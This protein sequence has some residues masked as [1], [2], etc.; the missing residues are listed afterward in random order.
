MSDAAVTCGHVVGRLAVI[1]GVELVRSGVVFIDFLIVFHEIIE[2][3]LDVLIGHL[4]IFG[5]MIGHTLIDCVIDSLIAVF[6]DVAGFVITIVRQQ[7]GFRIG[8]GSS[9]VLIRGIFGDCF[10]GRNKAVDDFFPLLFCGCSKS[11]FVIISKLIQS[12]FLALLQDQEVSDGVIQ[13]LLVDGCEQGGIL[14]I[15]A[16]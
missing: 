1:P 6:L 7:L 13:G 15:I 12:Q 8:A 9:L 10:V 16:V 4:K 3:S 5:K 11:G 2:V 14:R